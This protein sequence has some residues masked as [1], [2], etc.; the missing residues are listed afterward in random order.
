[1]RRLIVSLCAAVALILPVTSASASE[2]PPVGASACPAGYY[3]V[4]L[5][6]YDPNSG[7]TYVWACIPR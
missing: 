4:I 6:H 3:G 5:W 2:A 7:Y 1:M